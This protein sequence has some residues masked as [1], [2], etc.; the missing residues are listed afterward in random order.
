MSKP[1]PYD[2]RVKIIRLRKSGRTFSSISKSVGY[3]VK[4]VKRI[5]YRYCSEGEPGLATKYSK[6][7]RKSPF[8]STITEKVKEVRDGEQGAPYVRSMLMANHPEENI[9]HE[10]TLQRWWKNK[11]TNI[12]QGRPKKR[13]SWTDQA[14][15]TWQIDG[16]GPLLL[17]T[18]Q[19]VSWMKIADEATGSD[20]YTRLF[21]PGQ[22]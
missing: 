9:P 18:E 8:S 19:K 1:I 13:S 11:G 17:K 3:P 21:S 4:S 2:F 15:H 5:W 6:S 14:N 16:K 12:P 7:G 10:R 20:L 22:C